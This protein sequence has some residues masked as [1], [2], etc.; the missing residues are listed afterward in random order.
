M[1]TRRSLIQGVLALAAM[2]PLGRVVR[3]E[4][5]RTP[6]TATEALIL[7]DAARWERGRRAL[8][9]R[10]I[11]TR[12]IQAGPRI[13]YTIVQCDDGEWRTPEEIQALA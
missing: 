5:E 1:L 12:R 4:E 11:D 8:N 3:V 10:G 2:G 7:A 6:D 9:V 13:S